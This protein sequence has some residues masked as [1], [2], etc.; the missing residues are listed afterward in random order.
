M[1]AFPSSYWTYFACTPPDD[2]SVAAVWRMMH[3]P[4]VS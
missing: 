4:L 3:Q 2:D 1:L